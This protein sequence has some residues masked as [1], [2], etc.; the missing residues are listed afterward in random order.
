MTG[1]FKRQSR[2]PAYRINVYAIS[3]RHPLGVKPSGNVL[4]VTENLEETKKRRAML[5]GDFAKFSE[6][7]LL[8][9]LTY[10][11][12]QDLKNLSHCSRILYA[13][14]YSEDLWR[15]MYMK[16]YCRLGKAHSCGEIVPFASQKW[17]GSWRKSV[18]G[19]AHEAL[20]QSNDLIF[21]DILYR[22]YQCSKINYRML[23]KDIIELEEKSYHCCH[24]LNKQF[25]IERFREEDILQEGFKTK[26][27]EKPFI[28]QSA[29]VRDR[30]PNWDLDHLLKMFPEKCFRQEAVQWKLSK[31]IDYA[32]N[33]MDES[34]LYLFDCNGSPIKQIAEQYV[35]PSLFKSD[36][37]KLFK[38]EGIKCR[39]DHRWLIAGP[40]R[41]GSTFHK[42]PNQT[43]AWNTVLSGMKLWIM[44]PPEVKPPG[45]STDKD[46]DEVTAPVGISEWILSGFYNDSVQLALQGQCLIGIT[47]PGE[48]IYVPSGWWHSVINLTD[49]VALTENFVPEPVLGKVLYFLKNK[50]SQISGFHA[51]DVVRSVRAFI[52][53]SRDNVSTDDEDNYIQILQDFLDNSENYELDNEDCGVKSYS[54]LELPIFEFFIELIKKSPH[55]DALPA[56]LKCLHEMEGRVNNIA[57]KSAMWQKLKGSDEM[58]FSFG[59]SVE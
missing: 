53:E 27:V 18:L 3:P 15:N 21:S 17:R 34:P 20:P 45:V 44:L 14:A 1:E 23:F 12:D 7:L 43:S 5:L 29:T 2:L 41:S 49:T 22:P 38:K 24:S 55:R 46:E 48:C 9:V 42:D 32:R 37:F 6:E 16:E 4:L 26:Y 28:L 57:K 10:L 47:F 50:K 52:N 30:W 8:E 13:Y 51:K 59:L 19:I 56:A 31:Y 54:E 36:F 33:N 25:G 35:S 40:E 39:P 11:N 58:T